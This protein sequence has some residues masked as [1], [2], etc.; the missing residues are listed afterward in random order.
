[1]INTLSEQLHCL[2]ASQIKISIRC[3][4][5]YYQATATRI[6]LLPVWPS[7]D[8]IERPYDQGH[9]RKSEES[10]STLS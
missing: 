2:L 3:I 1:M 9:F 10:P 7:F 5:N 4:N 6:E 8:L